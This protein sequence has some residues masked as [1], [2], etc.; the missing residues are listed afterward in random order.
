[1]TH[2]DTIFVGTQFLQ[3]VAKGEHTE[4]DMKDFRQHL[5][6]AELILRLKSHDWSYQRSD[7]NK[8]FVKGQASLEKI[9]AFKHLVGAE[10]Y[11]YLYNQYAPKGYKIL[12]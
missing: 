2:F 11:K 1:M 8:V 7:D 5:Y 9:K 10:T 12:P 4:Q 3:R 6:E